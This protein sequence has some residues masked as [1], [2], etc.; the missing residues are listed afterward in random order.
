MSIHVLQLGPY[1]PPEGGVSRNMLAI[2][3]ELIKRGDKCSIIATS[4]SSSIKDEPDVY[5]P[6]GPAEITKLLSSIKYDVLHLHVGGELNRRV[7]G[8]ALIAS[9]FAGRKSVLT[10]HSGA[11][12]QTDEAKNAKS[13]SKHGIVFHRFGGIIAVNDALA[14]VFRRFGVADNRIHKIL[15]FALRL[16]DESVEVP[17]ELTDF[18]TEHSPLFLSVGGLEKDYDPLFQVEAMGEILRESPNA[19]LML[20]GEGSMRSEVENAVARSGYADNI[21]VAGNVEHA[22]TLHLIDRADILL[23]TTLFDGDAISVRE[24]IFLG[25]PVIATEN[26]MRPE[27]TYLIAIG[28]AESLVGKVREIITTP[29]SRSQRGSEDADNINAVIALYEQ[30]LAT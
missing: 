15:P 3:D 4:R 1:P 6:S 7:L 10:V 8:L 24:A 18:R 20:V 29:K 5:H 16:P 9:I 23:R 30:L 22:V 19:G 28:D 14:D 12:P 11:F 26:G 2:R 13:L 17:K 21:M 27:G 25:T